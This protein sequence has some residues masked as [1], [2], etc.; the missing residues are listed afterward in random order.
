MPLLKLWNALWGRAGKEQPVGK[1]V[2]GDIVGAEPQVGAPSP[3]A[4][5]SAGSR[6]ASDKAQ[7]TTTPPQVSTKAAKPGKSVFGLFGSNPHASLC[8]LAA[9]TNASIVLEVSVGDGSR[10]IAVVQALTQRGGTVRYVGIDQFELS[11]GSVTL[12]DFHRTTRAAGI[13]PQIY[14]ESTE[15]GLIRFLHTV[16]RADLVLLSSPDELLQDVRIRHLLTR[17]SHPKTT[18]LYRRGD[19]WLTLE[20]GSVSASRAA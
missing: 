15:R 3:A 8:K 13:R 16:G 4:K 20:N 9:A 18:V 5:A 17:I 14:P 11:G 1:Q 19:A 12:R 6:T 2:S 10:A 7:A